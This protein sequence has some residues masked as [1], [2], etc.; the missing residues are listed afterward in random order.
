[1]KFNNFFTNIGPSLA[2]NLPPQC[3]SHRKFMTDTYINSFLLSPTS[4]SEISSTVSSLRNSKSEG[5]D[6]L[7]I[8]PI[9]A[10]IHILASP[11]SYICNLSFSTGIFPVKLK[12]AKV[13]PVFKSDDITHFSN[14]RPISI[15]PCLS[16]V[17]QKLFY[18]RLYTFIT[19]LN[20]FKPSPIWL[21]TTLLY[22]HGSP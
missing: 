6:G 13:L 16:K 11:L 12:I 7:C 21:Q 20:N 1:M 10:S 3:E 8:S 19:K 5:L 18:F 9:K 4:P 14:Y 15:L 17:L 2:N 22:L